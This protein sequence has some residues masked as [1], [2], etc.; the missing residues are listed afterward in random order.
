VTTPPAATG[1]ITVTTPGG[2]ATSANYFFVPPPPLTVADI[3]DTRS[4]V[5]GSS[6]TVTVVHPGNDALLAF[7]ALGGQRVAF[8]FS[9]VTLSAAVTVIAPDG[10]TVRGAQGVGDGTFFDAFALPLTGTYSVWVDG[11]PGSTGTVGVQVWAVPPDATATAT[12]GGPAVTVTTTVAGQNATVTFAGTVGQVVAVQNTRDP[13]GFTDDEDVGVYN[14]GGSPLW[15]PA[16]RGAGFYTDRLT[17]PATGTYT[18]VLNPRNL[19]TGTNHVQVEDHGIAL[20]PVG[21]AG[22]PAAILAAWRTHAPTLPTAR[23]VYASLI[24]DRDKPGAIPA[25]DRRNDPPPAT[26]PEEWNPDASNRHGDW[27][28]SRPRSGWEDQPPLLADPGATALSGLVLDL[29]GEPLADVTLS[30]GGH[31]AT[32]D[33]TGRFLISDIDPTASTLA[34]DGSTARRPGRTYGFFEAHLQLNAGQTTVL[35]YTI[36]MPVLDVSHTVTIPAVTDHEVVVTTPKIPGL[37]LHIPA[38]DSL[39]DEDGNPV[40]E[41]G[42]TPIPIDRTPFPLPVNSVI[43]VYFT[44]QP[45]GAYVEPKGA[46]LVYPNYINADPGSRIDFFQYDPDG[47]GWYVYGHGTVTPGVDPVWWTP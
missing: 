22:G 42:I 18:V 41:L 32:S 43:P 1:R 37:E 45:G 10:S 6:A 46:W 28:A 9:G 15:G 2:S 35:P 39:V 44:I 14:P 31:D 7:D 4:V 40:T 11:A 33:D 5:V 17:L 25:Q 26:G 30:I 19:D 13:A 20:A 36:W 12:I 27:R 21:P 8:Q 47:R 38:G 3:D 29:R 34:I 23:P 24:R 16:G